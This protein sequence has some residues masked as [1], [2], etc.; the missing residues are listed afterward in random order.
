MVLFPFLLFQIRSFKPST[1]A[2]TLYQFCCLSLLFLCVL[3]V[4][5]SVSE[6][7]WDEPKIVISV[8]VFRSGLLSPYTRNCHR[9]TFLLSLRL[10]S[11]SDGRSLYFFSFSIWKSDPC[12]LP[13]H[14][15]H[16]FVLIRYH[17]FFVFSIRNVV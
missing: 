7:L 15:Y 1:S 9:N 13:V 8:P 11:L 6:L 14:W 2:F 4:S 10:H 12:F 16:L 5:S 17:K 3:H